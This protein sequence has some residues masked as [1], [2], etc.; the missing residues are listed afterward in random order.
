MGLHRMCVARC[1]A[2]YNTLRIRGL[3]YG[4]RAA[5]AFSTLE[6]KGRDRRNEPIHRSRSVS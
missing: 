2:P 1:V 6:R 4:T 5:T 3:I